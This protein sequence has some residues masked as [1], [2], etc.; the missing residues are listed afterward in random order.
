VFSNYSRHNVPDSAST[1][2]V[3]VEVSESPSKPGDRAR[4]SEDV[5][6]G[7]IAT[8][9]IASRHQVLSFWRHVA[10]H[11]YPTPFLSRDAVV[12]PPIGVFEEHLAFGVEETTLHRRHVVNARPR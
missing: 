12:D 8:R 6:N 5:V 11:G 3:M 4:L 9:V 7:L 2:S 1:W 10:P